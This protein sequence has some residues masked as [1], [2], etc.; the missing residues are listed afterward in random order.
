MTKNNM[1][2]ILKQ[3]KKSKITTTKHTILYNTEL[4]GHFQ[5]TLDVVLRHFTD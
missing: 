4:D 1:E 3:E 2:S 5:A